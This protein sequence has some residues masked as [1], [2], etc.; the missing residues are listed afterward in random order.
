LAGY[1]AV[2]F[3]KGLFSSPRNYLVKFEV[4]SSEPPIQCVA[5][6]KW[7]ECEADHSTSI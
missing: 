7:P 5:G 4:G 1:P 2:C 3:S 6:I